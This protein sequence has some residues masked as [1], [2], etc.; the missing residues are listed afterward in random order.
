[1]LSV[2]ILSVAM[3]DVAMLDA[4]APSL[5]SRKYTSSFISLQLRLGSKCF[6]G[7][8]QLGHVLTTFLRV[9]SIWYYNK[10]VCA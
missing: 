3:L 10:L 4:V 2:V 8:I 9:L 1:M 7:L 5:Y 6:I